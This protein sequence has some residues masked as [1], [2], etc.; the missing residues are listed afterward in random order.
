MHVTDRR[1]FQRAVCASGPRQTDP[2]APPDLRR[3]SPRCARCA[4]SARCSP[5]PWIACS[6]PPTARGGCSTSCGTCRTAWSSI[7]ARARRRARRWRPRDPGGHDRAARAARGAGRYAPGSPPAVPDTLLDRDRLA[8]AGV[9]PRPRGLPARRL[10]EGAVRVVSGTLRRFKEQLADRPPRAGRDARRLSCATGPV[11]PV[12]P[13]T[14]GISQRGPRA[15]HRGSPGRGCRRC[16]SGRTPPGSRQ[17]LAELR[18]RPAAR[19]PAGRRSRD[20]ARG[21]RRGAGSPSTSC[22]PTSWRWRW[23]AGA[24][25]RQRGPRARGRGPPAARRRW[26][27]CRFA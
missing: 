8:A 15:H 9:L 18:R 21:A 6:G 19:A 11:R 23:C 13:L 4:A 17:R 20:R 7:A 14:E 12:Y 26:P 22:S 10:A 25:E 27:P 24:R 16:R 5:R 1:R 3:C 2:A